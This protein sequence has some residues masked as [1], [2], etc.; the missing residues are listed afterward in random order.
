M[1]CY[2]CDNPATQVHTVY[3]QTDGIPY[4]FPKCSEHLDIDDLTNEALDLWKESNRF[5]HCWP[6]RRS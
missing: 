1:K 3:D 4:D 6:K 5:T 2:Y